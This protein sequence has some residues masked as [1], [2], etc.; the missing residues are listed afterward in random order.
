MSSAGCV[1]PCLIVGDDHVVHQIARRMSEKAGVRVKET[2]DALHR[3][4]AIPRIARNKPHRLV[5]AIE[6]GAQELIMKPLEA[7][8]PTGKMSG[9][10]M[11]SGGYT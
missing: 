3:L 4:K 2:V 7:D 1:R 10:A 8:M 6:A 5:A 11:P 9:M